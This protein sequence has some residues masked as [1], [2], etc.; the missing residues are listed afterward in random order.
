MLAKEV[1]VNDEDLVSGTQS[2]QGWTE[3]VYLVQLVEG[4]SIHLHVNAHHFIF[5]KVDQLI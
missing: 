5:T 1:N 4:V 3:Y 2:Q